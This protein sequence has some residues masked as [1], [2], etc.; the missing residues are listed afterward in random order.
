MVT[1][2]VPRWSEF[3]ELI[4][5]DRVTGLASQVQVDYDGS[6]ALSA[7]AKV[8]FTSAVGT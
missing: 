4:S 8:V 1:R 2:R 3:S 5:F 6:A 7:S